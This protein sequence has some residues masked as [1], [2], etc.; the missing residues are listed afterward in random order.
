VVGGFS[1]VVIYFGLE[2]GVKSLSRRNRLRD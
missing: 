1:P 2:T